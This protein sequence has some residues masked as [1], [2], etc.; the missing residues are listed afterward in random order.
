MTLQRDS[1]LMVQSNLDISNTHAK[2]KFVNYIKVSL[3]WNIYQGKSSQREMCYISIQW[4]SLYP[5]VY[6]VEFDCYVC[7]FCV[8]EGWKEKQFPS[9]LHCS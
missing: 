7:V 6:M 8:W 3:Y 9:F 2:Q 1:L 4:D 5:L